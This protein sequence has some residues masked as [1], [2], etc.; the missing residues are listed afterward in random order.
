MFLPAL[1]CWRGGCLSPQQA[2][3]TATQSPSSV[4]EALALRVA[5]QLQ[6]RGVNGIEHDVALVSQVEDPTLAQVESSRQSMTPATGNKSFA[7]V[8]RTPET[9]L[10]RF[11]ELHTRRDLL[12]LHSLFFNS[13]YRPP[14]QLVLSRC[15]EYARLGLL[16]N[17]EGRGIW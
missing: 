3:C 11:T 6:H 7:G 8:D 17:S 9:W 2:V 15:T 12:R 1:G 13:Q 4:P 14:R 10:L 5:F 16:F